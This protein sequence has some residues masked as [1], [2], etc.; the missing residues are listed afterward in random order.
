MT[1]DAKAQLQRELGDLPS[2]GRLSD[3]QAGVLRDAVKAARERQGHALAK[4]RD[5]AL[6]HVPAL[7]RGSVRKVLGA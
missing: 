2:I 6:G 7:L 1:A 5:E 4:A 3:E